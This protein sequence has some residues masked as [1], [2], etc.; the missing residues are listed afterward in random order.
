MKNLDTKEVKLHIF[1]PEHE[2]AL[3]ADCA[4][5]TLPH[6][7]QEFRMNMGFLP[8]LW[9]EDGDCVLVDDVPYAIKA[10]TLTGLPHKDV[11]FL[12]DS[13]VGSL[14]F[15]AVCPWGWD[16]AVRKRLIQDNISLNLLPYERELLDMRSLANRRMS[17]MVLANVRKGIE[18]ATCGESFY[19]T[20]VSE[21]ERLASAYGRII[22]KS[23]WSSSGRGVRYVDTELG[24][25][26]SAWIK[27]VIRMQGGVMVEPHYARVMD[28]AMEFTAVKKGCV[29]YNGLSLF[30]TEHGAYT[31]NIITTEEE[32]F[33]MLS[34]YIPQDMFNT[35]RARLA[36]SLDE[37]IKG[38]YRGPLGVDMMV[39]ANPVMESF[40]IH[41]CVEINLR[42]T[43]GHV[44]NSLKT[45]STIPMRIMQITHN[46]NYTLRVTTPEPGFVKVF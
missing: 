38:R 29:E 43:M 17:T 20:N 14:A 10:L 44:A 46:V 39:V 32:K 36:V 42:R 15:R 26:V 4:K 35:V 33:R 25:N 5:I 6:N 40:L 45:D 8:A 34:R 2:M 31:G 23:P 24:A 7:I 3:A 18:D 21:V 22:V 41:P 16:K 1:N 13:E 30:T 27:K 12:T 9:A 11:L 19:V 28:F 37:M